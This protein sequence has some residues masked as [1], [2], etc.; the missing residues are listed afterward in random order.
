MS[1]PTHLSRARL[2]SRISDAL[3]AGA[4][5]LVAPAGYGKTVALADALQ[6][7]HTATAWI[8]CDAADRDPGRLLRRL[9]STLADAAPGVAEPIGEKL[10]RAPAPVDV[11]ARA[12]EL[13]TA[14][15]RLVLDPLT[16]AFDD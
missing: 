10:S 15:E 11:E 6:A 13:A 1:G 3:D 16:I 5:L 9:V 14:L 12:Q 4:V 8:R 2:T 7:R